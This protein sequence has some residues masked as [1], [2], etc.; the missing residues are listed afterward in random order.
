[1][2]FFYPQSS[3][4][5]QIFYPH[6]TDGELIGRVVK[7]FTKGAKATGEAIVITMKMDNLCLPKT[8]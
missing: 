2:I 4:V 7:L 3:L 1:M 8:G 6:F 5:R